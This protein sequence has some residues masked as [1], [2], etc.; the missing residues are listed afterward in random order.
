LTAAFSLVVNCKNSG[1]VRIASV[2][3]MQSHVE[4]HLKRLLEGVIPA[5][6]AAPG[7]LTISV[8]RRSLV[9]YEEITTV[10]TWQS[11][12]HMQKFCESNPLPSQYG[13]FHEKEPPHVYQIV[14]N[15]SCAHEAE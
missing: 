8:L 5:Y 4:A 1:I 9:G 3:V 15:A 13:V 7:L 10:T 11:E 12:E 2:F 6:Q 14:F